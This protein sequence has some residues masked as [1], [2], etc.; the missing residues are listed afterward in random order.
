MCIKAYILSKTMVY[1]TRREK[2]DRDVRWTM[3]KAEG[4]GHWYYL[5]QLFQKVPDS[6]VGW[7]AEGPSGF[8]TPRL[9]GRGGGPS[10]LLLEFS[11]SGDEKVE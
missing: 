9:G 8:S 4:E 2:N 3:T 6:V 5:A 10:L 7:R 11:F 1:T